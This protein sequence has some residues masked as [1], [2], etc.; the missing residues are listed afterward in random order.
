MT[1]NR[2]VIGFTMIETQLD[3][4]SPLLYK[5]QGA[6][7]DSIALLSFVCSHGHRFYFF[8]NHS[9][10]ILQIRVWNN[11]LNVWDLVDVITDANDNDDNVVVERIERICV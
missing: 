7:N 10:W 4:T 5:T 11:R 6:I 2:M 1:N 9:R 3:R 8:K